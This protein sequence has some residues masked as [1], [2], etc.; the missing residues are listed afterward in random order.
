MFKHNGLTN[1]LIK[2]RHFGIVICSY[3]STYSYLPNNGVG[4][5]KRVGSK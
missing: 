5:N 1:N 2:F 3:F 4:P